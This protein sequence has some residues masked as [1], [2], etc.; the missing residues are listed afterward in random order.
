MKVTKANALNTSHLAVALRL[1]SSA[2]D[3]P[4]RIDTLVRWWFFSYR[5]L[6]ARRIR[7][8][9]SSSTELLSLDEPAKWVA[10]RPFALVT[11]IWAR[12]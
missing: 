1:Q 8:L 2:D 12:K 5:S 7:G 4:W 6:D 9:R 10:F 11:F 3:E